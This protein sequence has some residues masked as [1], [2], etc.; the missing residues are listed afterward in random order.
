MTKDC[1]PSRWDILQQKLRNLTTPE[2][3]DFLRNHPQLVIIDCR[4]RAEFAAAH[5]P[6]ARHIDYLAPD[7]WPQITQLP[8]DQVYLVYCNT[9]RRSAR[10]CTLMQNGGFQNVYNLRGGLQ[11]WMDIYGK[12]SLITGQ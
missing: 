8:T 6:Q 5:F 12:H 2:V 10:T 11:A 7:F 3:P 9:G 4:R 1:T